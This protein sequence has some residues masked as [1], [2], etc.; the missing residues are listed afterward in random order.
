MKAKI[1]LQLSIGLAM[2]LLLG[3]LAVLRTGSGPQI[4]L[5]WG[6]IL[7]VD[8]AGS[9]G[10]HTPCYTTVQA[11]VD[12]A[13][14]GDE[15]RVAAGTYTGVSAREGVTQVVYISKTVTIQGGY[16]TA[17]TDP[18][19]PVANPTVLSAAGQ[20]R[21]VYIVG[22]ITPTLAGLRLTG[23][24]ATGLGGY[25]DPDTCLL[26]TSPSPRDS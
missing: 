2:V 7:Y 22:A 4:A 17:Y 21:V 1:H 23:G 18:P 19:D 5:A 9:C 6:N 10:S 25:Y 15:I 20:G 13:A 12:T 8:A 3:T 14:T 26:Y 24:N 16:T 11:A